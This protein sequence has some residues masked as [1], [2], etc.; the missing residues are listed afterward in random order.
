[1]LPLITLI[2]II[3]LSSYESMPEEELVDLPDYPYK[4]AKIY[5]GYLDIENSVGKKLHYVLVLKEDDIDL[6]S[7][8]TLWL[9]GGPGCSSML[10]F[11]DE[12]GPAVFK[13]KSTEFELNNYSWN[14]I[15]H[16]LYLDSPAGVGFSIAKSDS[17]RITDD[18]I[19]SSNSHSALKSFFQKFPELIY[20]DFYI[21][22]ESYAGIYI[23]TLA[24]LIINSNK[25]L[26][27]KSKIINLKGIAIGNG[28]TDYNV[29]INNALPDFAYYHNLYP[30]EVR[31]RFEKACG[32]IRPIQPC[33]ECKESIKE[34]MTYLSGINIYD[35]YKKCYINEYNKYSKFKYAKFFEDNLNKFLQNESP[36]SVINFLQNNNNLKLT[37]PCVDAY[38]DKTYWNRED[39]KKA[40]N[41]DISINFEICSDNISY[42]SIIKGS[43]QF[44][45]FLIENNLKILIYS[46]DTDGAVPFTGTRSWID[47][48]NLDLIKSDKWLVNEE[49]VAGY[50][51]EYKE[52]LF[53]TLKGVGHMVPQWKREES[54]RMFDSF[55]NNK[56]L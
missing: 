47:S 32:L 27:D 45:P 13:E 36:N 55:I 4:K 50:Y 41:V 3:V 38:G 49:E 29:D 25:E 22:G 7:P 15:T 34:I 37:P 6:K 10:G 43:Y 24:F 2:I 8:L 48:L 56:P 53:V 30:R 44:Y 21:S 28:L 35:I 20:N 33:Y 23:P 9:N 19:T 14:K 52:L 40:L 16:M 17:D 26:S 46:G 5:S 18:W 1:M 11:S 42:S 39:V 31:K 51:Y 12:H 54:F